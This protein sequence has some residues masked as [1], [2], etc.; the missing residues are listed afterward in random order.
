MKVVFI[1]AN[2]RQGVSEKTG[3]AYSIAE[4]LYSIPDESGQKKNDDGSVRWTYQC[5]GNTT[6]TLPI[7]PSCLSQFVDVKPFSAIDVRLEPDPKNP[8]RN[9]ITGLA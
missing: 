9:R 4:L 2:H 1:G 7:D 3:N 8:S 5:A 6:R